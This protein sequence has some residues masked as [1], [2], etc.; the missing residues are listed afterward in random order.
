[1]R[2]YN[3][4][5]NLRQMS[6]ALATFVVV[7]L[8]LESAGLQHWA[9]RLELGP[10]R[11]VALPIANALHRALGPLRLERL[12]HST[13]VGLAHIRWSD[14]P[15]ALEEAAGTTPPTTASPAS[16]TAGTTAVAT[17]GTASPTN[18]P[19]PGTSTSQ[20]ITLPSTPLPLVEGAPP[21]LTPLPAIPLIEAGHTRTIALAG[22]SMMAV[23][24]SST[25]MR[26]GPQYKDVSFIRAFKSGT[27]LARPEVFNWQQEYPAMLQQRHPDFV[28]V[29]I[30]AN[31]GQGFVES[32]VT[33]QFG[34]PGWQ[35]IYQRRVK[36]YIEMLTASGAT[37]VWLELP[38]MK[39]PVYDARIALVNRIALTVVKSEPHAIW[40]STAGIIGDANGRFRD[41]GN[42]NGKAVKLRQGDGIHLSEDGG[43]L[44]AEK[45]L[46]WL[47]AQVPAPV[48]PAPAPPASNPP[49]AKP[50]GT[51]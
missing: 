42:V 22:D 33:Y 46:P 11:T 12:R 18:H 23:G 45:L 2:L 43:E 44:L 32:G 14:D 24:L 39:S 38:P 28:I 30:G 15:E 34:T 8:L 17:S 40:F 49:A 13:L 21:L 29:A 5:E 20:P 3:R 4:F 25:L 16:A 1:M 37:V 36:A 10:E 7:A 47:S 31:D 19:S 35:D 51:P 41:F 48:A 6:Y 50:E 26:E 27:G 9:D